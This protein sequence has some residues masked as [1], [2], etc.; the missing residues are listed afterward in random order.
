VRILGLDGLLVVVLIDVSRSVINSSTHIFGK[1]Y[2]FTQVWDLT[3]PGTGSHI[4]HRPTYILHPS[5]A[6]RRVVWRPEFEC[7]IALV[8]STEF[9][10]SSSDPPQASPGSNTSVSLT[11]AGSSSGLDSVFR[12][13]SSLDNIYATKG[14]LNIPTVPEPKASRVGDSVEIWDVRRGWIAKWSVTGSAGEGGVSG[15]AVS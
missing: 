12:G 9:G 5:F 13:S 10:T 7:E 1:F 11:R 15:R 8:S 14:K 4:P 2:P 3:A 6:V